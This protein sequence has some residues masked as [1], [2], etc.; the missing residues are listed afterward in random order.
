MRLARRQSLECRT[1][2]SLLEKRHGDGAASSRNLRRNFVGSEVLKHELYQL[3][4]AW[5][6]EWDSNPRYGF[7]YTRFPSVR[8][9]PL[10]HL[11]CEP[12][13]FLI[14]WSLRGDRNLEHYPAGRHSAHMG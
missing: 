5:R 9:K 10:G 6:R 2:W 12:A 14:L 7:P 11:S 8:L 13:S 4:N 1:N 3:F